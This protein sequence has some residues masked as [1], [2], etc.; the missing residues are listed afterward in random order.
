MT[1]GELVALTR[2]GD[3]SAFDELVRRYRLMA[4]RVACVALGH[5]EDRARDLAHESLLQAYLSLARLREPE[6]FASWLH[7]IVLNVCR[8]YQ[9]RQEPDYL[10][11]ET[12]AGGLRQPSVP[13]P[14]QIA[15]EQEAQ[16]RVQQLV[17]ALSPA[18]RAAFQ[19]FYGEQWS[20][21]EI[22]A[23]LDI[24]EDA[25]RVRLHRSRD[26][27]RVRL[28][29]YYVQERV[30]RSRVDAQRRKSKMVEVSVADVVQVDHLGAKATTVIL[31]DE[32]GR[33]A[34]PLW[35]GQPEA[36]SI[37]LGLRE[38]PST[39]RPMTIQ[40]IKGILQASGAQLEDIRI[41]ELRGDTYIAVT[42][43]RNGD[44]VQE[45]DSRPSDAIALAVHTGRP[46]YVAEEILLAQSK[47]VPENGKP[48][49]KGVEALMQQWEATVIPQPDPIAL[50]FGME[51]PAV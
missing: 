12:L 45:V 43:I 15:E 4:E 18:N 27:L 25:V 20:V 13:G 1:D 11:L 9:R 38:P 51:E 49:G 42:R 48:T 50:A 37:A 41:V 8:S 5:G 26:Y 14:Q 34:L 10:S 21:Q 44:R 22:A 40:F 23:A 6:R 24:S 46:I 29:P 39:L 3:R 2:T 17:E 31:H 32:A 35:I 33:R 47:P 30:S 36:M 19:L 7:G 28:A 16:E